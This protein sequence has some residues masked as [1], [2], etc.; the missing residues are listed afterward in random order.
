[1]NVYHADNCQ[2]LSMNTNKKFQSLHSD[3]SLSSVGKL[4]FQ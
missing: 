3:F 4:L 2:G 1:M